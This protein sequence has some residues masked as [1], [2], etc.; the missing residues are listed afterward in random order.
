[1][2]DRSL[3]SIPTSWTRRRDPAHGV[4]VTARSPH[5]PSSG[6]RPELTLHTA[7]LC[8]PPE[9]LASWREQAVSELARVLPD[10]ELEDADTFWLGD[11]EVA[12]H[13]FAHRVGL[14]DVLCDQWS[15]LLEGAGLTLTCSVAREDYLDHCDLF[16]AVA[17]TVEPGRAA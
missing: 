15:W 1:M 3:V 11:H 7:L 14:V 4:L 5:L 6:Y 16:E 17:E 8:P 9:S 2:T 10:F 13:R 12:Y